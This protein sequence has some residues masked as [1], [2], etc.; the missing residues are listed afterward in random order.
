[1][2]GEA[3]FKDEAKIKVSE[4]ELIKRNPQL[5][6]QTVIEALK[7][8]LNDNGISIDKL[9]EKSK[10]LIN[11]EIT[12]TD[13]VKKIKTQTIKEIGEVGAKSK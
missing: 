4:D 5:Y 12:D 8:R 7:Q 1:M 6:Q 3:E 9:S 10:Q 11:G 13:E 2:E